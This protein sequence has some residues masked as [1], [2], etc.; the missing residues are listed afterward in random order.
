MGDWLATLDPS[1]YGSVVIPSVAIIVS[2]CIAVGALLVQQR[3]ARLERVR[4][5]AANV[6]RAIARV[7][8]AADARHKGEPNQLERE[9]ANFDAETDALSFELTRWSRPVAYVIRNEL[10]GAHL[11][12]TSTWDLLVECGLVSR[13]LSSW[14]VGSLR[15][16][17]FRRVAPF[18][19]ATAPS[20][21][22]FPELWQRQLDLSWSYFYPDPSEIP[23]PL[24]EDLQKMVK[25]RAYKRLQHRAKIHHR[26][27]L[28]MR[29]SSLWASSRL[30]GQPHPQEPEV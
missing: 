23:D 27:T 17:K 29:L 12:A 6:G 24:P 19:G 21:F 9:I 14:M 18:I 26:E 10:I 4:A 2:T 11:N 8:A 30:R 28:R 25:S 1:L 20:D 22:D 16:R 3:S 13:Y 15:A 5:A 7:H